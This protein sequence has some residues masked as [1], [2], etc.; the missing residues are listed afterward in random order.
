[1]KIQELIKAIEKSAPYRE[2]QSLSSTEKTVILSSTS[3]S[4]YSVILAAQWLER[5]G[6][7][8]A[9]MQDR[10]SASYLYNDL[11]NILEGYGKEESVMLLPTAYRR[12]ITTD[13]EDPSGIVQRTAV[14]TAIER[15]ESKIICTWGDALSEKVASNEELADSRLT[16]KVGESIPMASLEQTLEGYKFKRVE[17]VTLPGEYALRGGILDIFSYSTSKPYRLDFLGDEVDSIR[18]FLPSTQLSDESQ[19]SITIVGNLKQK[20]KKD[21]RISFAK[22]LTNAT[23]DNASIRA[24]LGNASQTI[25]GMDS[26]REKAA[27]QGV[28]S[29]ICTSSEFIAQ[30]KNWS[31]IY[32]STDTTQ[33][34][35]KTRIDFGASIQPS[36]SR[37]FELF[38]REVETNYYNGIASYLLTANV[39]QAERVDKIFKEIK[40][41]DTRP[42]IH[43]I[44]I[45]L[46]SGFI[47]PSIHL[48]LYTDHQLFE[49]Y[50]RYRVRGEIDKATGMTMAEFSALR[51]GDYVV[52][53]DHGIG[54]FSGLVRQKDSDTG[55]IKEFI[56]LTYRDG[57][58]LFVRVQNLHRISKY[59]SG[60]GLSTPPVLQKLGS[61]AWAKLKQTTKRKVKDIAREL[62]RLYAKRKLSEGFAF[63]PDSY[64]QRELEASFIYE[65]TA[66]QRSTTDAIKSDME[67]REPMDRLVCGD[68]GFGKTEIAI[69]AAFKAATDSKQVAVLV[70]TTV[71]SLQHY[72]TFSRRLKDFPVRI[73]NFSRANSP[74][75]TKEILA[76]LEAGRIDILIGTHKLLGKT[77]KYK[78]LGLLI[79]DEEQKFGVA[80]KEKLRELKSSIDTLTLT[81]TPIP[82]TLQ[83][84]LMGARDMSIINTPPPNRQPVSTEV[85]TFSDEIIREAVEYELSRG[86]QVFFLHNRVQ[87][88]GR[89]AAMIE[90]LVPGAKVAV[91]H[92][93]MSPKE[94]EAI[95]L[96]FI[97]GEYNVL[98]A[99]TIIE[100]GI[101]IPNANTIIINQ[102]QMFGLSDL[103][104]L[105]GRVGRTNRKA[106][107]YLLVPSMDAISTDAER[108]LRAIEEFAD[109]GSGFNIAM[110][111]LDIRGAGNILGAEQSGFMADIGYETYQRIV[112][113]AMS[114]LYVEMADEL[115]DDFKAKAPDSLSTIDCSVEIDTS[116]HLPDNYIG[117]TSEKLKLYRELE[118]ITEESALESFILKLTDRFGKPPKE[119]YE[120]FEVVL[121]RSDAAKL[122]FDKVVIKKGVAMLYFAHSAQSPY[123]N[124]DTFQRILNHVMAN[125]RSFSFKEG[126]KLSLIVTG[127][128]SAKELRER[129]KM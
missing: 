72:R 128:K 83:F 3:G 96:D 67:S 25:K 105:R 112:A 121:L 123:F 11:Y 21:E 44:P 77:V 40:F 120:L 124:S 99:T 113:E 13:R 109:L 106:F 61:N 15:N 66:D 102:A 86:G 9:I 118:N 20:D 6:Y 49:R 46:H 62:I 57:D 88:I 31:Y 60:D 93:Q 87:S 53:I 32:R 47:M 48:A 116:A 82:R 111:D 122:G 5:G 125:P 41:T 85:H 2:F 74:K 119:A 34:T 64:L 73:E 84:S 28:S 78:D 18:T 23:K 22:F 10:D 26:L 29:E 89:V 92:G 69:R 52:H 4:L 14:L 110:Q 103:H 81:A 126:G 43:N 33:R 100:S 114:E 59:K 19:Q 129:I 54:R 51:V 101:D 12:A 127:V 94:L 107:C 1:M 45:T 16:I 97:Y 115:G 55:A 63:S 76:D 7:T 80:V 35:T 38:A 108:R 58:A 90:N 37:N 91:G 95:M 70:P 36:F 39:D 65:D 27:T 117:S 17:F 8:I 71:L 104:Q 30:S 56:K 24:W 79:I 98:V 68:V 42:P 50:L 75:K